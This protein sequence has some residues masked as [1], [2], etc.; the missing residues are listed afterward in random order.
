[1]VKEYVALM[2]D[3]LKLNW[4]FEAVLDHKAAEVKS[5]NKPVEVDERPVIK[6]E[7]TPGTSSKPKFKRPYQNDDGIWLVSFVVD[8]EEI[9]EEVEDAGDIKQAAEAA[10][11]QWN[12]G[13]SL[14]RKAPEPLIT[15]DGEYWRSH[16]NVNGKRICAVWTKSKMESRNGSLSMYRKFLR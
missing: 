3:K 4:L 7:N 8:N 1:M 12:Y 6:K 9:I 16:I 5:R 11:E 15:K 2:D 10:W 13:K 14:P